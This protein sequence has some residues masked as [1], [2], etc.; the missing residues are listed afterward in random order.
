MTTAI[1]TQ[2][3]T[4]TRLYVQVVGDLNWHITD[5]SPELIDIVK[6]SLDYQEEEGSIIQATIPR[7]WAAYTSHTKSVATCAFEASSKYM[8]HMLGMELDGDDRYWYIQHQDCVNA[9]LPLAYTFNVIQS[10][11]KPYN[12]GIS[13]IFYKKGS[14]ITQEGY[15]WLKYLPPNPMALHNKSTSNKEFAFAMGME[16]KEVDE[17]YRTV[18]VD[19]IHEPVILFSAC[20]STTFA[21]GGGHASYAGPRGRKDSWK[22][23]IQLDFLDMIPYREVPPEYPYT[24]TDN[25]ILSIWTCKGKDGQ[26]LASKRKP[27]VTS[28]YHNH[29]KKDSDIPKTPVF[30]PEEEFGTLIKSYP[31]FLVPTDKA[32]LTPLTEQ[33]KDKITDLYLSCLYILRTQYG[34][35]EK[36]MQKVNVSSPYELYTKSYKDPLL[37]TISKDIAKYLLVSYGKGAFSLTEICYLY[38][39]VES[40]DLSQVNN[41]SLLSAVIE[42]GIENLLTQFTCDQALA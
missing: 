31:G 33:S 7:E 10:L 9:G 19:T 16:E 32:M 29:T 6:Q 5:A 27:I 40:R 25:K 2:P 28:Y 3:I 20:E 17:E 35:I 15:E 39:L 13:K 36:V 30:D 37:V 23:A 8:K 22:L 26:I 4:K 12:L 14:F 1:A 42:L 11:I 21:Q 24:P 34:G 38:F 18:F 41:N